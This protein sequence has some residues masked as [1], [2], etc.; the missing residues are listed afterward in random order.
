MFEARAGARLNAH[1]Y[2]IF[3]RKLHSRFGCNDDRYY[4]TYGSIEMPAWPIRNH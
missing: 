4:T 1:L 3:V 2:A